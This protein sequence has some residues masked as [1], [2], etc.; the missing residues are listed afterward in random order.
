MSAT[1]NGPG[2]FCSPIKDEEVDDGGR[3]SSP[4]VS[5][6][7]PQ[8]SPRGLLRAP[9]CGND[10]RGRR[11]RQKRAEKPKDTS[12][13]L[14]HEPHVCKAL[15]TCKNK[16]GDGMGGV[17][18]NDCAG[19]GNCYTAP[20]HVCHGKNDCRGLGACD[21]GT[22]PDY[23]PGYPGEN[24]CKAMGGCQVPTLPGK[25]KMWR[26]SR[27]RFECSGRMPARGS[28]RRRRTGRNFEGPRD[29]I[30][31]PTCTARAVTSH[32]SRPIDLSEGPDT[33]GPRP[34][35]FTGHA[36]HP[37]PPSF[38]GYPN[39]GFGVGLRSK[40]Y[41]YI[42]EYRP[43]VDWFEIISENYMDSLGRP[44][45]V[46]RQIAEL[47]L[48]VMMAPPFPSAAPIRSISTTWANSSTSPLR[49][50]LLG[51]G[52]R[53]LDGGGGAE[54]ALTPARPLQRED[55][56]PRHPPHPRRAG[57]PRVALGP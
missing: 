16:G 28:A 37:P 50:W 10:D 39:L 47:Y 49:S 31:S 14:L 40:H 25:E 30:W 5:S 12:N 35:A 18:M 17:G 6:R 8:V 52:P 43:E 21:T 45:S 36:M 22:W 46:L 4:G 24:T 56:G 23:Q 53:L 33:S 26:Q 38:L 11:R 15:N 34:F 20:K 13:P 1:S 57:L 42:L 51:L 2:I 48:V 7:F 29:N 41:P 9:G 54:H 3:S 27:C 44:R 19:Q 32:V 55:A